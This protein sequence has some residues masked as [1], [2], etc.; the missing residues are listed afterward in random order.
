M[1]GRLVMIA[2]A[3]VGA[4]LMY[5]ADPRMGRRRRALVGDQLMHAQRMLNRSA[6]KTSRDLSNRARG[7][8]AEMRASLKS[9]VVSDEV[10]LA[11]V[12]AEL[13]FLVS[14]PSAIEVMAEGGH[15]RLSGPVLTSEVKQLLKGVS[16]VRGVTSV[17]NQLDVHKQPENVQGLQGGPPRPVTGRQFELM[18]TYWS[19]AG[20]LLA[21]SIGAALAMWGARSRGV[22]GPMLGLPGM[23]LFLRALTNLELKRL[24]GAGAGRRAV[25]FQKT[26]HID[27]PVERVFQLWADYRNFPR[28]MSHVQEVKDLGDGRSH[29]IVAGL[30]AIPVEWDAVVSAYIPNEILAWRTEPN[31]LI[32]HAGIV[33]F[34]PNAWGGTTVE[35]RLSYNP[36]IGAV[37]H[38]LAMLFGVDPKHQM[39]DDLLRMKSFVETGKT[40]SDAG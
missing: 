39:D 12:R 34:Q 1:N 35:V 32:Q 5:F 23:L 36:G 26:L 33:R 6:R 18:Q 27:A 21:G 25:D 9:D 19:P 3:A 14:H 15:V 17:A 20:R 7:L 22:Y 8:T 29:W 37:G 38:A 24:V 4:G 30:A 40:P 31:S 28:F 11:R 16:S 10:L 2:G 13:G